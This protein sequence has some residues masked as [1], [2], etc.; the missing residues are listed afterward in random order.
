MNI[1]NWLVVIFAFLATASA[2]E[3]QEESESLW[4]SEA[5]ATHYA[6]KDSELQESLLGLEYMLIRYSADSNWGGFAYTYHDDEYWNAFVGATYTVAESFEFG[7]GV[8][9]ANYDEQDWFTW[10]PWFAFETE[11][12]AGTLYLEFIPAEN[13]S[14]EWFWKYHFERR[15]GKENKWF[16]GIYG[17]RWMGNGPLLGYSWNNH[18]STWISKPINSDF[19][20]LAAVVWTF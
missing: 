18:L 8:G 13:N 17:E 12:L 5:Q 7:L 14:E 15:F 4:W 19:E 6:T 16:A 10:N 2:V 3:A 1:K 11:K 20:V 9:N